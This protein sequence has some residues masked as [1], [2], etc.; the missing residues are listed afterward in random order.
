MLMLLLYTGNISAQVNVRDSVFSFS[1]GSITGG[2]QVPGGDMADRFGLNFNI[3]AGCFRKLHNNWVFGVQGEFMFGDQVKD[4]QFLINLATSQG[5]LLTKD[6]TYGEVLLYERGWQVQSKVGKIIPVV[7]PNDNSGILLMA[8][9][10]FIQHKIRIEN[11]G[12]EIPYL[13]GDYVKGYDRLTNGWTI[14]GF[15]GY[16]NFGNRKRVNF[17]IGLE[18]IVGMTESRRD[19]NFDTRRKDNQKRSDILYG[20]KAGWII[21]FYKKM[22]NAFYYD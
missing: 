11:Q 5:Y 1:F 14:S 18:Y 13:E 3:G 6:G 15:A 2:F 10:G 8:G 7:G 17:F 12:S 19:F 20:L 16:A 9:A 4:R 22:P 21:P